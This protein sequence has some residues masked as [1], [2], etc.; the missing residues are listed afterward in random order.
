VTLCG[1]SAT[2]LL[3]LA[4]PQ[5]QDDDFVRAA[6]PSLGVDAG[7]EAGAG[8]SGGALQGQAG[9]GG[10]GS[11]GGTKIALLASLKG[12]LSHRYSFDGSGTEIADS[13]AEAHGTLYNAN[14]DGRGFAELLGD[15]GFVNLPNG[16][17]SSSNDKTL[18]AWLIWKGGGRWQR[19]FDFG[20]SDRGES[21]RGQGTSYLYLTTRGTADAMSVAYSTNGIIGETRLVSSVAL[22]VGSR[23]HVA[24][25]ID[26][27]TDSFAL[28]VNGALDASRTLV[29]RL[30]EISD[31]NSWLGLAQYETDPGLNADLLE[32][33]LYDQALSAAEVGL[34]FELGADAVI[35]TEAVP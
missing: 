34:S 19:V 1:W 7:N 11:A 9:E 14:L 32:F 21:Q 15:D 13:I 30:S 2:L 23:V 29:Q 22:P 27:Q 33:R 24:V 5:L 3:L 25:V 17:L 28:Y 35:S 18:E 10:T 6:P 16:L 26:S 12:A 4:C 20:S 8:G 31:V